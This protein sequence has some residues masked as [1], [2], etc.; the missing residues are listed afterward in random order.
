MRCRVDGAPHVRL[1]FLDSEL[2][3]ARSRDVARR[4]RDGLPLF[5]GLRGVP[6]CAALARR[7]R[8]PD[9]RRHQGL[10]ANGQSLYLIL[11]EPPKLWG[12]LSES[13][14]YEI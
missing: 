2:L 3:E 9:L 12:N 14:N 6:V 8:V 10:D 1:M 7:I 5:R 13:R 4:V 11:P